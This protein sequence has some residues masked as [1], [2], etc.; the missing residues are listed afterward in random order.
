MT[1]NDNTTASYSEQYLQQRLET[2]AHDELQPDNNTQNAASY[3]ELY[4]QSDK[5]TE[6]SHQASEPPRP[7]ELETI[8]QQAYTPPPTAEIAKG[9]NSAEPP[10]KTPILARATPVSLS[11]KAER[12]LA[13][14]ARELDMLQT[15]L[16]AAKS[17]VK[18]LCFTSCFD[19][20][21]K[22]TAALNAAYGLS[23][24]GENKVLL[25]D[26][27]I[28]HPRLHQLFSTPLQ[29]GLQDILAEQCSIEDALHPSSYSALDFISAGESGEGNLS[30]MQLERFLDATESAYDYIII[31]SSAALTTSEPSRLA[32]LVDGMVLVVACEQTKRDVALNAAEKMHNAGGEVIGVILNKRRFHIPKKIYQWLS[33]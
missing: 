20:E 10:P 26:A 15:N 24:G 28:N 1:T 14:N 21:G 11:R 3:A 32:P 13:G 19:G 31:D 17:Q 2:E 22:T 16:A 5:P 33:R 23:S 7:P 12:Q 27:N 8:E 18:S 25:I 29:P 6:A 4:S 9:N 30:L